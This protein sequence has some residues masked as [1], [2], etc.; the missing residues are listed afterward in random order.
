MDVLG[1]AA[2]HGRRHVEV[3]LLG[4]RRRRRIARRPGGRPPRRRLAVRPDAD[5][6][7]RA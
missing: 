6:R 7:P 2:D 5:S 1:L 3:E 4:R